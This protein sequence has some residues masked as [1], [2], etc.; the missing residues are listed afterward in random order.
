MTSVENLQ[1]VRKNLNLKTSKN[2][3][4]GSRQHKRSF[5]VVYLLQQTFKV[6]SKLPM[7]KSTC[8][9]KFPLSFNIDLPT[10]GI[11]SETLRANRFMDKNQYIH[12]VVILTPLVLKNKHFSIHCHECLQVSKVFH[13]DVFQVPFHFTI[14]NEISQNSYCALYSCIFFIKSQESNIV[15]CIGLVRSRHK[16]K[17]K[18]PSLPYFQMDMSLEHLQTNKRK[19]KS[20]NSLHNQADKQIQTFH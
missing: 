11:N 18:L 5:N 2:K 14:N 9:Q 19:V 20:V 6:P 3:L 1:Q 12:N 4:S 8:I 10:L 16:E 15:T 17:R 7:Q 13:T